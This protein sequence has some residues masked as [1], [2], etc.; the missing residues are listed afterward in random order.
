MTITT[1]TLQ[2]FCAGPRDPR[3][4]LRRPYRQDGRIFA[5]NGALFVSIQDDGRPL[6]APHES[7]AQ[8]MAPIASLLPNGDGMAIQGLPPAILCPGCDGSGRDP[9]CDGPCIWCDGLGEAISP[10]FDAGIEIGPGRFQ[11]RL[12]QALPGVV[13][14]PGRDERSMAG[15]RFDG[16]GIGGIMPLRREG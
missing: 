2:R 6:D 14:V 10:N 8:R 7:E 13:I 12:L 1:E 11:A 15:I 4:W 9:V 16:G 3:D 5:A